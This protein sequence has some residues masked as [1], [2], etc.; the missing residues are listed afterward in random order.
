MEPQVKQDIRGWYDLREQ[1]KADLAR[2]KKKNV[3]LTEIN[4]LLILRNFATLRLKG[5][6]R[7]PA[8]Q[9]IARQWHEG[10]GV[11]FAR[12]IRQLACHYQL[13]E[14]LPIEKRGGDRGH[15]L[16]NDEHVQ[17][18]ARQYLSGLA[19]GEVTP[20]LFRRALNEQ[21]LPT[22]GFHLKTGLSNRTARHWLIKLGWRRTRLKKGVYMDGHERPDVRKYRDKEFLPRMAEYEKFMVQWVVEGKGQEMVRKEPQLMPGEE[23]IIPLFQDES[24]LHAREY[25]ANVWLCVGEQK[26]MKKGRSRIIH[27]SDFV[28]EENGR[29]VIH[30]E[31]GNIVK[32]AQRI[33]YPGSNGDP[34][35]DHIQLLSQVD[36]AIDI[37]EEAHPDCVALFVFDQ[38]SAHASLGP[39]AL[40]AFDMNKSNGGKQ[41]KQKDTVIPMNN[42]TAELRSKVQRM[43]TDTGEAKGLRQT[44]EERR[45]NITGMKAKCSPVCPFENDCCC[46]A[47]LLSKQDDFHYQESLLE[48]KI[49]ARGHLCIFLPKFHCELNP[50]EMYW[51]WCKYRYREVYKEKF[52]D[53]K[54]VAREC[55]DACPV[56][57]IRRFFNRSWRFMDAYRKGLKGKAAEWAVR[58]QKSHRRIAQSAMMSIDALVS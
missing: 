42:P 45:F 35:W 17:A 2:S 19:A 9:E 50:I 36:N 40:R 33:N 53:A 38:S 52:E 23:R 24:S 51:G 29:L 14:Q 39:D 8:S 26:L 5:F 1:I 43:T 47:R 27:V 22:L 15:S 25:K 46:M 28:E 49:K 13:F 6:E 57:V 20:K 4:Q 37:F 55:L 11:H 41:R 7:I 30:D 48:L 32:D 18:A 3:I 12:R 58:K 44:L 16:L 31:H 21:I 34:W 56:E 10:E 54:R